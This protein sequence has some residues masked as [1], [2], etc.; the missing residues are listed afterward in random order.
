MSTT[1]RRLILVTTMLA[2]GAAGALTMNFS[3]PYGELLRTGM[4]RLS[5]ARRLPAGVVAVI[6]PFNVP[7]ILAIRA[8]RPAQQGDEDDEQGRHEEDP[9]DR[10]P[11]EEEALDVGRWHWVRE[12]LQ[13]SPEFPSHMRPMD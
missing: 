10:V 6:A 3:H 9:E 12:S 1:M 4:P 8:E 11:V 7:T 5:F 13:K 2:S